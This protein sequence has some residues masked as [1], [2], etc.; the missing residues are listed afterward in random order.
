MSLGGE[1]FSEMDVIT[2]VIIYFE[3]LILRFIG[4]YFS[5][6]ILLYLSHFVIRGEAEVLRFFE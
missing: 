5:K 3:K 4:K 6:Q 1:Q 2:M